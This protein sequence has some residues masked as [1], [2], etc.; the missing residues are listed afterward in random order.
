MPDEFTFFLDVESLG[1]LAREV[2]IDMLPLY[3]STWETKDVPIAELWIGGRDELLT[4]DE[5]AQLKKAMR[6][7]WALPVRGKVFVVDEASL[8]SHAQRLGTPDAIRDAGG[9][10]H[11]E[12]SPEC[13]YFVTDRQE[14]GEA[15]LR[16]GAKQVV[17]TLT[18]S[19]LVGSKD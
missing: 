5:R 6:E 4:K 3:A 15:A 13:D 17:N 9:I 7:V 2:L 1:R 18:L 10:V 16:A 12:V 14:A 11:K 8:R 19:V